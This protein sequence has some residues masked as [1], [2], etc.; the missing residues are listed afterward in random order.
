MKLYQDVALNELEPTGRWVYSER[1]ATSI[2]YLW[3]GF[4]N[5]VS[6]Y[7]NDFIVCMS[8]KWNKILEMA[9]ALL[10]ITFQTILSLASFASFA[11]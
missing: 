10:V 4:S 2:V 1:S 5:I 11:H 8:F 9:E 3:R 6:T 7:L